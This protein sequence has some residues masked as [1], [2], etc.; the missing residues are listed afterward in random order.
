MTEKEKEDQN[1]K[2]EREEFLREY[3]QQLLMNDG[4]VGQTMMF[5]LIGIVLL[6]VGCSY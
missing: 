1:E 5:V 2:E 6:I 3:Q 4:C